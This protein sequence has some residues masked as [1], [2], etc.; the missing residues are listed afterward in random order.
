MQ[1]S[2]R[3]YRQR[4]TATLVTALLFAALLPLHI[5]LAQTRADTFIVAQGLDPRS[6]SPLSSTAQ[7]EKNV[8][9]QI[10][11][12]LIIYSH[13]GSDFIPVL[14][15]DWE[16]VAPDT[17]Q[18]RLREG[19]SFT[20][21][22][23][24]NAEAAAYGVNLMIQAPAY[25]GF[26]GMLDRAEVVDEYTI[27]VIAKQPAPERL[28]VTAL[29]LG[30]FMY[31][32]EYTDQVGY[33]DG[34]A[35]APIGTGPFM[36][37]E[38][39]RDDRVVLDANPDYWGG[40]PGVET[41]I[42]RP[43]PEGSAR[44]AAL[45]AG[46]IDFSIDI[47]LDAWNRVSNNP[48]LVA[49][50]APGGRAYRLTFTTLWDHP[51]AERAVREA[52]SHAIDREA[53]VEFM[54]DGLGSLLEGQPAE[55]A[56]FG[57][58]PELRSPP[59]DPERARQLL[60]EAGYPDGFSLTFKYSSGRYP[61]DREVGEFVASQLEAIG[62]DVNQVVLESGEFLTQLSNLELRDMFYSGGLSP[63]DAHFPFTSF[64]CDFRYAYWCDEEYDDLMARA[65]FETDPEERLALY[66]RAIE[67]LH[68]DYAVLP[69]YTMDDLYA[70]Q[71]GIT[72][73]MPMRDQ[74]LDFRNISKN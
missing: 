64:T 53:I 38:W 67:I 35:T 44:V 2:N 9:N 43:I 16:M 29:A 60:A 72:G 45:E 59:Y 39:V 32:P 1:D 61:Q 51:L 24:F 30:S 5:A 48:N 31:P 23:P 34:F 21:G 33:L 71:P 22:E 36:L 15:T 47:P 62:L 20:N 18:V 41:L 46:D 10:V 66:Q 26:T 14:A 6:L 52:L 7:Q 57:Y 69:L 25:L 13:D 40:P 3:S 37:R 65:Q 55:P 11:E 58:N 63:T 56:M 28:M 42:F 8:S 68:D 50:N 70:H 19:V 49:I 17:L 54:F 4:V 73:F 27:N 74:Y 12:R